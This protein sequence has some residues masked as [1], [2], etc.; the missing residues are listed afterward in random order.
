MDYDE[1]RNRIAGRADF[2]IQRTKPH[3]DLCLVD[4]KGSRHR[5]KYV[6]P[7]QLHWYAMLYRLRFGTLPDKLAFLYWKF[8]PPESVDWV[9]FSEEALDHLLGEVRSAFVQID[10]GRKAL[11]KT[12][13]GTLQ[14]LAREQ[15]H[16]KPNSD[17]CRFC[18]YASKMTC[19]AGAGFAPRT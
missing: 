19:P 17:N 15:F 6:D 14:V 11:P 9:D 16:P 8:A 12:D 4:G 13:P 1:G 7:R 2:I 18:V 10:R 5:G 3:G